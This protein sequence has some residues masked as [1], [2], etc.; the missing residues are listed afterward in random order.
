MKGGT[1]VYANSLKKQN[2]NGITVKV[3]ILR[4]KTSNISSSKKISTRN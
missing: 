3:R 2:T 1:I 4:I